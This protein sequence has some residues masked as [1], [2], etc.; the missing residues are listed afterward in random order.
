M[1]LQT[2]KD[3][4]CHIFSYWYLDNWLFFLSETLPH[5]DQFIGKRRVKKKI[6][7]RPWRVIAFF[8]SS[9]E[10][11]RNVSLFLRL[12]ISFQPHIFHLFLMIDVMKMAFVIT[13][14][15]APQGLSWKKA[16]ISYITSKN[17]STFCCPLNYL[18]NAASEQMRKCRRLN[19]T[20][21]CCIL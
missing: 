3:S 5:L 9:E 12:L 20:E 6:S 19:A 15:D 10:N 7:E 4:K 21:L 2:M 18:Q 11:R 17:T 8:C 14:T 16:N 13:Q 1:T